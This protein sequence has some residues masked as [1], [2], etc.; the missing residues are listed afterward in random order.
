M[1]KKIEFIDG[2]TATVDTTVLA[3]TL[4]TLQNDGVIDGAFFKGFMKEE[5]DMSPLPLLQAV[6]AAYIQHNGKKG[7]K[8]YDEF[9]ES[10]VLD[11]EVDMIVYFAVITKQGRNTL[12]EKFEKKTGKAG[13]KK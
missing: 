2:S 7:S 12:A 6:Y 4:L 10:Y 3:K 13:V 5:V 1:E 11:M 8:S 9:L